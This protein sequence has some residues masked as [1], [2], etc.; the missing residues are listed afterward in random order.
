MQMT[1]QGLN[2]VWPAEGVRIAGKVIA[3]V[4]FPSKATSGEHG[5]ILVGEGKLN[6]S[7]SRWLSIIVLDVFIKFL[8]VAIVGLFVTYGLISIDSIVIAAIAFSLLHFV[9]LI[10]GGNPRGDARAVWRAIAADAAV[11]GQRRARQ[12]IVRRCACRVDVARSE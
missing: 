10:V 1:T 11:Y 8:L 7:A 2:E 5:L 12:Y 3:R 4:S 9:C 6:L